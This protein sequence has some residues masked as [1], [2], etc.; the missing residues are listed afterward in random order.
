MQKNKITIEAIDW[1][2]NKNS[3]I[4]L[5]QQIIDYISK[6]ITSG[7]W[8]INDIIPS[9]RELANKFKV[10]RSTIVYALD[11]LIAY[12]ILETES[13]SGT[14][15]ANNTWSL[16]YNDNNLNWKTYINAGEFIENIP[17]IQIINE[18]EFKDYIRLST[19]ELAPKLFPLQKFQ[20]ISSL[21]TNKI[22]SLNY[23]GP[24][25]LLELREELVKHLAKVNIKATTDNILITS[26]SLQALQLL[27]IAM[28]KPNAKVYTE[29]PTYLKSLQLFQSAKINLKGI[30]MDQEGIKYWQI[31]KDNNDST[32]LYTIPDF[33]N[34]TGITCSLTRREELLKFAQANQLAIIE[35]SAYTELYID[36]Q[37]PPSLKSLDNSNQV[38]YLGTASKSLAPGLRVGWIVGPESI[39]KR[40]GDVKMQIDYGASSMSQWLMYEFFHSGEYDNHLQNIR[41]ELKKRRDEILSFLNENFNKHASWTIPKGGFYIYIQFNQKISIETLFKKA[42]HKKILLNPGNIYDYKDNNAIRV[43]YVY[44]DIETLKESLLVI[45]KLIKSEEKQGK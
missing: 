1:Q 6:K 11:E 23:L 13:G 34:P 27:S 25:G 7:A 24:L 12:G 33:H 28:I 20:K 45:L 41:Q 38:L 31:N 42:L 37:P 9:Q 35:D 39:I 16:L 43:S 4:P 3:K 29:T 14:K 32:F 18:L 17:T 36:E 15:V 8:L 44:E 30:E 5:Y 2:P 22:T 26:G 40:L 21:L 10:N 19:G